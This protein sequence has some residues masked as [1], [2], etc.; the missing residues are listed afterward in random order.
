MVEA[1]LDLSSDVQPDVRAVRQEV[2]DDVSGK[3]GELS[4]AVDK[5]STKAAAD[6]AAQQQKSG[7]VTLEQV[8]GMLRQQ[9]S[10][11]SDSASLASKDLAQLPAKFDESLT[12]FTEFDDL[13]LSG[14][15]ESVLLGEDAAEAGKRDKA[16]RLDALSKLS[17]PLE[18]AVTKLS[19]AGITMRDDFIDFAEMCAAKRVR[20]CVLSRGLK[21]L[22]RLLLREQGLG[23][24]EVLANDMYVQRDSDHAWSVSFRDDSETGH[25]KGESLRRAMQGTRGGGKSKPTVL[26]LGKHLCDFAPVRAGLVDCLYAPPGSELAKA[27]AAASATFRN[28]DGWQELTSRLLAAA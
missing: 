1:T 18:D 23:H 13:C 26:V 20:L 17:M 11:S 27:A 10:S 19:G 5:L 7:S 15:S 3:L 14:N 2:I 12:I 28:F 22:I 24:V 9:M 21:S 25:D 16:A 4:A 6:L 8:H